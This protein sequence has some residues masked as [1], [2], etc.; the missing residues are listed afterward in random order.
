[1]QH[2]FLIGLSGSG[3]STVGSLLAQKLGKPLLDIDMLIEE[4]CGERIPTIFTRYGE[5]YFRTCESRVLLKATQMAQGAVI[6]TGGGVVVRSENRALMKA[7]GIRVFLHV[8]PEVALVRLQEQQRMAQ[9]HGNKPEERPLLSGPDPLARLQQLLAIRM[10]WYEEAELVCRTQGKSAEQVVQEIVAMLNKIDESADG[11]PMVRR[12]QLGPDSYDAIVEWG[13]I[14]RLATYLKRL[15]LPPRI[16]MVTDSNIHDLY[17]P[18][19]ITQLT[20]AGFEP[21]VYTIPAGEASKS[22][23]QLNALYDWLI[24]Q[25]AERREAIIALG[26]GVVG[27]LVGY[28]AATYLRGVPLVQIP[29][30]LLAQVDSAIGGK[31][32]INH[33]KGKNLIGAFYHPRL[34]LADPAVLLTLPARQRIEGWAEIVKYGIILDAE[35]FALLEKHVD[36]LHDFN[37]SPT[38]LLCQIIARCID[39]KV[40][41]IEEDER[42]QGRRAILNYG[43]TIGHALENVSGYGEWLHGEAVSL[44]M[45]AAAQLAQEAGMF[46][47]AEAIRQ[48]T[49]LAKLGLPTAYRGDVQARDILAKIQLDKKVV[50]KRVRWVMPRH[51]GEVVVTPMPDEIVQRVVTTF[52]AEKR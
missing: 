1:M 46:S 19:L 49:L 11:A 45:V 42:E 20:D 35:L 48:N 43:H 29:T 30:S 3:K 28:V 17:V 33:P 50:G 24:E 34:M 8:E 6:A 51:I 12:V 44:G 36:V 23:Q 40:T 38:A 37:H 52:F 2:V 10:P 18:G 32:G 5:D 9:V 21:H 15:Q 39:L 41:V 26:G 16:F 7:S 14:G 13:G 47:A 25:Y 4:E 27:D 31:C 22:Q